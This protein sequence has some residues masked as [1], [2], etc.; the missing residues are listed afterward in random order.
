MAYIVYSVHENEGWQKKT[1][2][3]NL[4]KFRVWSSQCVWMLIYKVQWHVYL[5]AIFV[6]GIFF[7]LVVVVVVVVMNDSVSR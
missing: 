7:S 6:M 4:N 3:D 2:I 1:H 5:V